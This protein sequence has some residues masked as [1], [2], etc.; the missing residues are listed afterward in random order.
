VDLGKFYLT[1]AN[2]ISETSN[3]MLNIYQFGDHTKF[4]SAP[5]SVDGNYL[6]TTDIDAYKNENDYNQVQR[7]LKGEWRSSGESLGWMGGLDLRDNIYENKVTYLQDFALSTSPFGRTTWNALNV[8]GTVTSDNKTK[9]RMYAG[10][11]ELKYRLS[12]PLILTVNGRFDHIKLNY[13]DYLPAAPATNLSKSF[14]VGSWR[15]GLNYE[16]SDSVSLYSNVSTG[17]RAP[18]VSQ[19]FA[20][21]ISPS[22]DTAANPN[23]E[24]E[25]AINYEIGLR[26]RFD[27][28]GGLEWDI[29]A[30]QIDRK[31]Y[32]LNVAGQYA[33]PIGGVPLS[34]QYQNIGGM[35]SRGV[36][37]AVKSDQSQMVSMDVA[38]TFLDAK[39]TQ[40]DNFNLLLGDPWGAYTLESYNNTGNAIPRAP[41]HKLFLAANVKPV[42]G[43]T[44]TAEM[45]AQSSYFVD[46]LNWHKVGGHTVF[47]LI[48]NYDF[49]TGSNNAINWNLFARVDNVLDRT[50]YNTARGYRD[51]NNDFT[52]DAEDFSIVV[53][54]GRRYT[55]GISVTF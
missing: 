2:D 35:R 10:Y 44:V 5:V 1:Y 28:I 20:G 48:A 16:F 37:V 53:N 22:G 34:D 14:N 9:E 30:F 13:E 42:T 18:T 40:Y 38:Y 29:A 31:D 32:I 19:L 15:G 26:G 6:A 47:D 45:L 41:K 24:P 8:A 33:N 11:G 3:L 39:F 54:P 27:V 17:F 25:K 23:L 43:L 50:Y 36:E 4:W 21:R 49:S 55:T 7:G 52:Y 46:E 12:K 51:S